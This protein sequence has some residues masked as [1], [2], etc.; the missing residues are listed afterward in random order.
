MRGVLTE[1][2]EQLGAAVRALFT[3]QSSEAAVRKSME[4]A[5]GFD[6]D[7]WT[8]MA[9]QMG[10]LALAIPEQFGGDGYG[11]EEI[12]VVMTEMGR[13]LYCG[14][15]LSSIVMFA[16][17]LAATGDDD[18]C[19]EF[20]PSIGA[21]AK[22]GTVALSE[23]GESWSPDGVNLVARADGSKFVLN[24]VKTHVI[25]GH[26]ADV[27]L[28]VARTESGIGLF[29]VDSAD[30]G[31][32]K[33]SQP[34]L[35]RT[36]RQATLAFNDVHGRL[37]GSGVQGWDAV[38]RMLDVAAIALANEQVG[39][40]ERVLDMSVH[41]A[42]ERT[43]FGRPIGSFQAVKHKCADML[44]MLESSRSTARLAAAADAADDHSVSVLASLAQSVC[45]EA[46]SKAASENI[47]IHGGIGF[48]W[49]H[50]AHLYFK[51]ARS[52]EVMFGGPDHHRR[53]LGDI[54]G[55]LPSR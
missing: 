28:V 9:E 6:R 21:G 15:Y 46:F 2:Q 26:I 3:D 50:P 27:I 7:L 40:L 19:A 45:S 12:G 44:V 24:G 43:Q 10:L 52:S 25:D 53:V 20:L 11:S 48:T 34:T 38:A 14:P 42:K 23:E 37:V 41:Y 4:T 54:S 33:T 22:I 8:K 5:E 13:A 29:L 36:R 47:Q 35:D 32:M 30:E 1:E 51:R 39:G 31:L 18:A 49:E 16:T 17:A 55:L